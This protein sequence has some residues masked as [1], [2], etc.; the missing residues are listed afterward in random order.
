MGWAASAPV[1]SCGA[2]RGAGA[3]EAGR[4]LPGPPP[5]PSGAHLPSRG[6]RQRKS[7]S[8]ETLSHWRN[9]RLCLDLL[10]RKHGRCRPQ[11]QVLPPGRVQRTS[12]DSDSDHSAV[13]TVGL[14]RAEQTTG[15]QPASCLTTAK[16]VSMLRLE[17]SR[18]NLEFRNS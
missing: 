7:K 16:G 5:S 17:S 6:H 14:E 12:P 4:G 3:A 2:Q 11:A 9:R 15:R 1:P 18:E 13:A 10:A 8:H